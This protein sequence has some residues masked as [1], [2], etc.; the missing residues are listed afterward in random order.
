MNL[1][2]CGRR[3]SS[4]RGGWTAGL[5]LAV[6][7]LAAVSGP[8][9]G[10]AEAGDAGEGRAILE[11]CANYYAGLKSV[12][13]EMEV[14]IEL[15]E[16]FTG[17]QPME[18]MHYQ[19]ALEQP[20]RA[21]FTPT[22]ERPEPIFVQ[23]GKQQYTEMTPFSQYILTEST[24]TMAGLAGEGTGSGIM[25]PGAAL[26][27]GF[28]LAA[29][30]GSALRSA[31]EVTLLGEE[32]VGETACHHLTLKGGAFEGEV[33]VQTGDQ[34]WILRCYTVE[35]DKEPE[36]QGQGMMI[37][38]RLDFHFSGWQ[39]DPDLAG[40]F[41]I[42]VNEEFKK[43][44]QFSPPGG[45]PGGPG[46][47]PAKDH[48]SLNKPAPEVTLHPLDGEPLSLSSLKG[49]V[50]VLDFWATW[51]KPCVMS[52]PGVAAL[53]AEMKGRDVVFFAV[54]QMESREKVTAFLEKEKLEIN[55]T[56]DSKGKAAQVFGV[57][58]IPHLVVIG[59]DGVVRQVHIGYAPGGDARLKEEV[60]AL[61]K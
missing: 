46:D 31:E 13:G 8:V 19:L 22:G 48:P 36:A 4:F 58:G 35:P 43:V 18:P 34:P 61:L 26:V 59:P 29:D 25:I 30:S 9:F 38:P 23:D 6:L 39:A 54:N 28:G 16:K 37:V 3:I 52:M 56:L 51:C 55:V 32:T 12:S 21:A 50:V 60:E 45:G 40:R 53:A 42:Q 5:T 27:V 14:R 1:K 57:R 49:K 17:G 7:L 10:E 20:A 24:T 41:E 33:W 2:N 15:P 11:R 44:D 47:D